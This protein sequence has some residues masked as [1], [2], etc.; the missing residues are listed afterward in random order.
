MRYQ[1]QNLQS[2]LKENFDKL[3]WNDKYKFAFLI[4]NAIVCIHNEEII[5]CDLVRKQ[6]FIFLFLI[7]TIY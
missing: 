6:S 1:N 7:S 5:H 3:E 2:Y 4:A